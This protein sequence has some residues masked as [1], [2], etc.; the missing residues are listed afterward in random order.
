MR[1]YSLP[2][3]MI[4]ED[5][6]Q[7]LAADCSKCPV[8]LAVDRAL[9]PLGLMCYVWSLD[10]D[11]TNKKRDWVGMNVYHSPN[12]KN[13]IRSFDLKMLDKSAFKLLP[14]FTLVIPIPEKLEYL[15]NL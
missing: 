10:M 13:W 2:I 4:R 11:I 3:T 12:I 8:A 1:T 6:D 7:G 5:I 9:K 15:F 14:P